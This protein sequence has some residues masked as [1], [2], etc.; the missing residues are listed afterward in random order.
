MSCAA[1]S[2][3]SNV[4]YLLASLVALLS[5]PIDSAAMQ[6]P[7][8]RTRSVGSFFSNQHA[9]TV[10]TSS[11]SSPAFSAAAVEPLA[12]APADAS[13]AWTVGS[14]TS[15]PAPVHPTLTVSAPPAGSN[16]STAVP[17]DGVHTPPEGFTSVPLPA[18]HFGNLITVKL[19]PDNYIFLRAQVLPL[20][21]SHYLLGYID[22]SLPCHPALVESV[23]DPVYNPVHRVWMGQDQENLSSIHGSLTLAARAS[24]LRRELGECEKLDTTATEF[25]NKAKALADTLASIG[26]LL[27]DS[28]FN[29]F[30]VNDLDEEYDG[31][32]EI[33]NERGNSNPMMVHEIYSRLLLTEQCVEAR[34]ANR[35]HGSPSAHAAYKG[36][37]P[38]SGA[39]SSGKGSAPPLPSS[40][41][42]STLP[43]SGGRRVCQLCG[44]VGHWDSKC[45]HC[46]Q[47][48]FLGLGN[49]GKDTRNNARQV[50]MADRRAPPPKS[51]G[52]T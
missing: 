16:P 17:A 48:S 40:A 52:H 8:I 35:S 32:V 12:F 3:S 2:G 7:P 21:G 18:F 39:P 45:H 19:S 27:T 10:H 37:H 1:A 44:L 14:S 31:L 9:L 42:P 25:Y 15:G 13:S 20:L 47:K 24:A 51:Q 29:F 30:I 36:G 50:A 28:E 38:S 5:R 41:P 23:N 26:Q 4:G 49:D 34:R 6:S 11:T 46:F 33:I 43:D 22:D